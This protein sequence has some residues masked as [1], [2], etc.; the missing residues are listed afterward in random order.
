VTPTAPSGEIDRLVR[1][2]GSDGPVVAVGGRT[3]WE[4]GGE[5]AASRGVRAPAGIVAVEPEDMTVQVRAGTTLAELDAALAEVG[6]R[7]VLEGPD[8]TRSTVGGTLAVGRSGPRRLGDGPVRDAVLGLTWISAEGR[9]VMAGGATVKNVSGFDLCRL[10]V[11]SL[12]TLGIFAETVLRTR[13]R[14][15]CSRWLTGPADPI[16]LRRALFAPVSLLWDG[17]RCWV[18][19]EGHPSDVDHQSGLAADLGCRDAGQGPPP[20]PPHRTSIPPGDLA[21]IG[22]ERPG[23]FVAE[24]GVGVVHLDHPGPAAEIDPIVAER[25]RR[26]KQALDPTG[27]L[28]PGRT[29]WPQ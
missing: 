25:C 8:P 29:A 20:L 6:Q 2:V 4:V 28:A 12:G 18:L 16:E 26:V 14:A 22:K 21:R 19:L 1:D 27:R 24:M 13:P 7:T 9:R 10:M 17:R 3:R 11:G 23:T 15:D 5:P